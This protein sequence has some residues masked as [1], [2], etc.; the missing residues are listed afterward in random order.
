MSAAELKKSTEAGLVHLILKQIKADD[1]ENRAVKDFYKRLTP[2]NKIRIENRDIKLLADKEDFIK[3]YI[4]KRCKLITPELI[5][6]CLEEL[7]EYNPDFTNKDNKFQRAIHWQLLKDNNIE[8]GSSWIVHKYDE[9]KLIKEVVIN[10]VEYL[11]S[12]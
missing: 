1:L 5:L 7:E 3:D 8:Y 2:N 4:K 10:Y 12:K 11:T 9:L 6:T